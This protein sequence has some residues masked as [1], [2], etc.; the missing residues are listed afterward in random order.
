MSSS[1]I[2]HKVKP[3]DCLSSIACSHGMSWKTVLTGVADEDTR[4]ALALFQEQEGLEPTGE[5]D[6]PAR[7]KLVEVHGA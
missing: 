2:R 6:D 1:G 4:S 3:G 7:S 5:L